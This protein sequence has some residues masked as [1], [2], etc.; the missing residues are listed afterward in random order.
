MD[1]KVM[2]Q[3]PGANKG[4]I[5]RQH[6]IKDATIPT[7]GWD[8]LKYWFGKDFTKVPTCNGWRLDM[9]KLVVPN[10]YLDID[11]LKVVAPNF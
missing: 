6:A 5:D 8:M 3:G 11:L 7:T 9:G 2:F 10:V 4:F 1:G